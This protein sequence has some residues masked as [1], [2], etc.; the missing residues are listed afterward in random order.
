MPFF[1]PNR[2]NDFWRIMGIAV[3]GDRQHLIDPATETFRLD[4]IR[5]MLKDLH[6]AM[7]DTAAKVR[8]LRE[9]ASDKYLDIVEPVDLQSLLVR[10][11]DCTEIATTGQ[12][13]AEVIATLTSSAVPQMGHFVETDFAGRKIRHWRMPS[14]SRAYPMSITSKAAYYSDMLHTI[15]L[16]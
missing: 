13:A 4:D 7:W 9:N 10:M 11:P 15:G 16:I 6:I 2:I 8:R 3:Y 14:T 12:K 5:R 1:Y